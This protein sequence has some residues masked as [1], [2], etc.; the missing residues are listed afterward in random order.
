MSHDDFDAFA[1][2]PRSNPRPPHSER[3]TVAFDR[4][5]YGGPAPYEPQRFEQQRHEP[6]RQEQQRHEPQRQEPQ[7]HEPQRQEQGAPY[8]REDPPPPRRRRH[9]WV[10]VIAAV[11]LALAGTTGM[12]LV[13]GGLGGGDTTPRAGDT[14]GAGVPDV[15]APSGPGASFPVGAPDTNAPI[16][17][18]PAAPSRGT[19]ASGAAPGAPA[20]GA[21][22][23]GA[24]GGSRPGGIT[25]GGGP[26]VQHPKPTGN[27]RAIPN[28]VGMSVNDALRTLRATGFRASTL[29]IAVNN[30]AQVGK[31]LRQSPD[32]GAPL[33]RGLGVTVLAGAGRR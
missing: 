26:T 27:Q 21:P 11:V 20:P 22:A 9:H 17:P 3:P 33:D 29:F 18:P 7:R 30:P 14:V 13:M 10:W 25:P 24:P 15:S 8:D 28:V 5:D 2:R 32:A 6:P 23:P 19:G 16:P 1:S 12:M 4:P 31:V